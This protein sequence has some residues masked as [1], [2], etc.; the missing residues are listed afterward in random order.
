MPIESGTA[1]AVP[2]CPIAANQA[3]GAEAATENPI[4][5]RTG[6]RPDNPEGIRILMKVERLIRQGKFTEAVAY[7][8]VS[9]LRLEDD[10][11]KRLVRVALDAGKEPYLP[12]ERLHGK[13]PRTL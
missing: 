8:S 4:A 6:I 12:K 2:E 1:S 13:L 7:M 11:R 9:R 3:D 10:A 5:K